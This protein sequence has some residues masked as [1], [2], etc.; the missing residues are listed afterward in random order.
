MKTAGYVM[1]GH[2]GRPS[3]SWFEQVADRSGL[4]FYVLRIQPDVAFEYLG[5]ALQTRLGIPVNAG[6]PVNT[7]EVL[8]RIDPE[9]ADKLTET[10]M[11]RPGQELT[12][13]GKWRHVDGRSV[14]SRAWMRAIERP[15]GSVVQ[16]GVVLDITELR[17][18]EAEL[19]RSEQRSRLL[20]ENAYDVIW[21]M[22]MD[23]TVNYV[24]P[25]VQR[26]RGF[27]PEEAMHQKVEEINPPESAARVAEYYQRVFA[28][29]EAGIEPPTFRG[30]MEYYRKDGSIMTG[31]LQVIP[32]VD[33]DG[34]VVELLGVTRDISERKMLEAELTRLAI[35][36][37][38]TGL[39]NR[40]RG[41][42]FL[43]AQTTQADREREPLSA[44]MVDIDNF[45]SINDTFGHQAGDRVLID[46]ARRLAG[47][48][49]GTDMVARWGGE[50]FVIMLRDCRLDD[51]VDRADRIRRQIADEP[52]TGVGTVTV[53]IGAA[54]LTADEESGAWL[55]RADKALYQ[56]KRLGR[57][58]VVAGERS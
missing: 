27:T 36:D 56:A 40:H 45:K 14:Y 48:V 2:G 46:L 11:M 1:S 26:V 12:M 10:L 20:A 55:A 29:I 25:A 41:R 13:D 7:E 17:E 15:D 58:R 31:E 24:S 44:L 6:V 38:V 4:V 8:G 50:E 49:R 54:Q 51:A 35:T 42:E 28:A 18:V 37:P 47:S 19:R 32:L 3:S 43:V 53:S 39:W 33:A 52:F 21:T 30:E 57:N 22:A 16:E 34:H 5:T 9:S 23:G